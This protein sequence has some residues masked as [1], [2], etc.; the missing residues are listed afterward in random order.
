MRRRH[1]RWH[2]RLWLILP[3]LIALALM[4]ALILRPVAPTGSG[5]LV[6]GSVR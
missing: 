1:R 5:P 6:S 4:A 3:G 2:R